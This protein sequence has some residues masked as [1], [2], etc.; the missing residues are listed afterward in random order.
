MRG[1]PDPVLQPS[2]ARLRSSRGDMLDGGRAM[3]ADL[4][5]YFDRANEAIDRAAG[6]YSPQDKVKWLALAKEYLALVRRAEK[7]R[8]PGAG[9]KVDRVGPEA[10]GLAP[11]VSRLAASTSSAGRPGPWDRRCGC[12]PGI[13]PPPGRSRSTRSRRSRRR[14]RIPRATADHRARPG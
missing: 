10:R 9:G 8:E 11:R 5:R 13:R 7:R 6:C 14:S 4:D 3:S 2:A 12:G 1:L